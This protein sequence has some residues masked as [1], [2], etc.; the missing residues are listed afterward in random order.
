MDDLL[1][2]DELGLQRNLPVAIP[3]APLPLLVLLLTWLR[4][5]RQ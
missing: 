5:H 3:L 1:V 2:E 4:G